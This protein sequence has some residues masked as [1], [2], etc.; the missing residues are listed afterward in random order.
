MGSS[1]DDIKRRYANTGAV[2]APISPLD[3]IRQRYAPPP[4]E[5]STLEEIGDSANTVATNAGNTLLAGMAPHI[6]A[7]IQQG[8]SGLQGM[9]GVGAGGEDAKLREQGFNVPNAA[10]EDSYIQ[11]R[12][13][14]IADLEQMNKEHPY[15]AGAGKVLGTVASGILGGAALGRLGL[16]MAP[17]ALEQLSRL[18]R[19]KALAPT[20]F[21]GGVASGA[22]QNPGDVAG[23]ESPWQLKDRAINAATGGIAGLVGLGGGEGLGAAKDYLKNKAYWNAFKALGTYPSTIVNAAGKVKDRLFKQRQLNIGRDVLD[24]GVLDSPGILSPLPSIET[25]AGRAKGLANDT[26]GKLEGTINKITAQNP[27]LASS[28]RELEDVAIASMKK[29]AQGLTDSEEKAARDKIRDIFNNKES[30]LNFAENEAAKRMASARSDWNPRNGPKPLQE[31]SMEGLA[32]AS[33]EASEKMAANPSIAPELN[34]NFLN[35]KELYGNAATA[36]KMAQR[37]AGKLQGNHGVSLTDTL[38]GLTGAGIGAGS[39]NNTEERAKHALYGLSA[40]LGSNFLRKYGRTAA[41]KLLNMAGNSAGLF[42]DAALEN[43]FATGIISQEALAPY[44]LGIG[45]KKETE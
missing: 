34:T 6:N 38:V 31:R 19:F 26:W 24:N 15:A 14:N 7:R 10:S 21:A 36:A 1:L 13:R 12:D 25:I 37:H 33:K 43:P 23:E 5:K 8:L 16:G 28:P 22:V 17:E 44:T 27:A 20:A 30:P 18:Q 11:Q 41:A 4:P 45:K 42:G 39:G 32:T 35:E 40:G 9:L 29:G 3:T 2:A